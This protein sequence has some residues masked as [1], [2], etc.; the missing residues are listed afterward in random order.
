M[1]KSNLLVVFNLETDL[2][3]S[4]LGNNLDWLRSFQGLAEEIW[5]VSTHQGKEKPSL[6]N[7]RYFELGGGSFS[8]RLLALTRLIIIGVKIGKR[9]S[10]AIVFHH[11][12]HRTAVFPGLLFCLLGIPQGL[13]Y[14][15][16]SRP[17]LLYLAVRIVDVIFSPDEYCFPIS[18]QKVFAV[19]QPIDYDTFSVHQVK[20]KNRHKNRVVSVGRVSRAK[21][22]ESFAQINHSTSKTPEKVLLDFIGPVSDFQYRDELSATFEQSSLKIIFEGLVSRHQLPAKL[23]KYSFFFSGTPK[24]VDRAAIEA[25]YAGCIPLSE[26]PALLRLTGMA[27]IWSLRGFVN[28]PTITE[29]WNY[30]NSSDNAELDTISEQITENCRSKN[31]FKNTVGAV[32]STLLRLRD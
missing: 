3:S 19:G 15:H 24:G 32:V 21:N 10:D 13:W 16:A 17:A 29:Q 4:L 30:L 9:K 26:N 31:N 7:F 1:K 20:H 18:T 23:A 6:Q 8:K 5:V 14:S 2:R 27:Y 28:T 22:I 11:M 12:S 25:V